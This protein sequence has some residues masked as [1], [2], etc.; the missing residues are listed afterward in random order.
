MTALDQLNPDFRDMLCALIDEGVRFLVVGAYAV[1]F[2]GHP[3]TTG[4]IDLWVR[5]DAD[6]ATRVWRALERFGAPRA[7]L[8]LDES[9]FARPDNVV[10]LGVLPRRIDLLTSV[11]GVSFDAA[12]PHRVEVA[13]ESRIVPFLGIDDLLRNKRATARAKAGSIARGWSGD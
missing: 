2:H 8:G 13:W 3:R 10:Q 7:A 4:D 9:D 11:S 1:S 6:N 12:W 5:P